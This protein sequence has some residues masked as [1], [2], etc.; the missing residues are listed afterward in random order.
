[1]M[2][3]ERMKQLFSTPVYGVR[4]IIE[5]DMQLLFEDS[6]GKSP[7][8]LFVLNVEAA[9][10]EEKLTMEKITSISRLAKI[11]Q[12]AYMNLQNEAIGAASIFG[13]SIPLIV[14]L[15]CKASQIG[16][17]IDPPKN[18][19][20]RLKG[21]DFIF[22]NSILQMELNS[23]LKMEFWKTAFAPYYNIQPEKK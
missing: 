4:K 13:Q 15:G 8:L 5:P 11:E 12:A 14:A 17:H 2:N 6:T 22:T 9:S 3:G 21:M 1:M 16:L 19:V 10:S 20:I 7:A 18:K 23:K